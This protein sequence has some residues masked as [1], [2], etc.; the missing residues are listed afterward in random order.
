[1]RVSPIRGQLASRARLQRDTVQRS[2]LFSDNKTE[3]YHVRDNAGLTDF[4]YMQKFSVPEE[5]GFDL[6]DSLAAGNVAKI[7]FGR[8][9][10]TFIPDDNG[11]ILADCYIAN[12]DDELLVFCESITDDAKLRSIFTASP[13]VKDLT[14]THAVLV[15]TGI[16]R[17][18]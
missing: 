1:M 17:G 6:L 12:N 8:V 5:S 3:Y 16:K 2:P 18:L 14:E 4:S 9:L 7:R 10:H 13:D 11:M 15:L